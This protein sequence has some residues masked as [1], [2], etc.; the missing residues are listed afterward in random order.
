[1]DYKEKVSEQ[2]DKS[3]KKEQ[4]SWLGFFIKNYRFTYLIIIAIIIFGLVALFTL[5]KESEPEVKVPYALVSTV[6]VGASPSDIESTITNKIEDKIK[7]LENLNTFTSTSA[8]GFSSIFVEF[9]AGTDLQDSLNKLREAVDLAEAELP[10]Q[11]DSPRVSE[12]RLSDYP[13]VTYSLIGDYNDQQLKIYADIL[14]NELDAVKD[15][16]KVEIIGGL[17][18]EFQVIIDQTK[19]SL[20]NL[21]L[22][23]VVNSINI[24]NFSLPAGTIEIDNFRYNVRIKGKVG[25]SADLENLV[26]AT[27]NNSPV[28]LKDVANVKDTFKEKNTESRIGYPGTKPQNTISLQVYKKQGGNIINIVENSQEAINNLKRTN[29]IPEQIKIEKTN[30]NSVFIKKDLGILGSSAI[31]TFILIALILLAILSLRGAII[32]ALAVPIAFLMSFM[33][34]QFQGMTLNTMV[35]FALVLSLGLMVDNAIVIIEGINEYTEKHKKS[36]YKAAILSVWNF[37]AAI[38]SGT[39]TT[40]SAFLPLL[41]VT[42]IMG[43]YISILPKTLTLTLLSSLFVALIIIPTLVTRFIKIKKHNKEKPKERR[44]HVYIKKILNKLA[45]N[46]RN[47]LEKILPYKK[48][49]V[50]VIIGALMLFLV[51]V[52]LPLSGFIRIEMF[53]KIDFDYFYINIELPAGSNLEK[54]EQIT[55]KVEDIIKDSESLDNY[56]TNIGSQVSAF[57]RA[58]SS[59]NSENK[60]S[61]TVNLKPAKERNLSSIEISEKLR[62]KITSVSGA[63]I[64]IDELSAGPPTGSPIEI[65]IFSNNNQDLGKLSEQIEKYL[66]SQGDIIN[67]N[68]SLTDSTGEFVFTINKQQANYYGLSSSAI[69]STVR[70]ALFGTTASVINIDNEDVDI[71]VKYAKEEFKNINDLK[72]LILLTPTGQ[73]ISLKQVAEV[74][75]E[76]SLLSIDHKDGKQIATITADIKK[77]GD[78]QNI[79]QDFLNYKDKLNLSE[80]TSIEVGGE[81]E[82]LEKSFQEMAFAMLIAVLLIGMILILQFNSFKQPFIILFSLPLSI[83]GV[84][85][86]LLLLN[87]SFSISVFIGIVSL[88]GIVVNAGIVLI[89]RINKNIKN[90]VDFHEAVIEGGIARMQPILITSITTIVGIIPLI[91]ASELWRGL[92]ISI[93]FGLLFATFLNLIFVPILYTSMCRKKI[94]KK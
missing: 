18:R 16:S 53:P 94:L 51:S 6:Y 22:S 44:R 45:I 5:P 59:S 75:I 83:I 68:S 80:N 2:L 93:I 74:K 55:K 17:E 66:S 27:Y 76:P 1:M 61:I 37:K 42:G 72:E 14:E 52:A 21:S 36:I 84:M 50:S 91:F 15:V 11:V 82:E 8:L 4:K 3:F 25:E 30:D 35:L 48:R 9:N 26:I 78:L 86:G 71:V 47:T 77:N 39:L 28:F 56:V 46:Y 33:F 7:N 65:R 90:G 81:K 88:A 20:F 19:L 89:D 40:V 24:N 67:I 54:T 92:S 73:T 57:S 63:K 12:I 38:T 85:F 34:L 58:S 32:T 41:L 79:T 23:Q 87:M 31:Q 70:S 43:E 60:A 13:I 49:R 62:N 69:A 29:K 10:S 64:T